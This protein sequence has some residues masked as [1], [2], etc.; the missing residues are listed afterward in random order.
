M[1][2]YL[3]AEWGRAV[4][5]SYFRVF[6]LVLLALTAGLSLL[7]RSGLGGMF[8]G[9]FGDSLS[10]LIPFFTVGLYLAVVVADEAFSDQHRNDTPKNEVLLG[11]PRRRIYLGKL[12]TA[13]ETSLLLAFLT[14]L[15]YAVLCRVLLPGTVGGWA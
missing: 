11:L 8:Q 6:L 15:V 3:A 5:R 14:L 12:V 9:S 4:A 13:A 10:L 1:K 2:H 7:W